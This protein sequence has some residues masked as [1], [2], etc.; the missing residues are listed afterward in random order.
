[1]L[2]SPLFIRLC[3]D[4]VSSRRS[5]EDTEA[6]YVLDTLQIVANMIAQIFSSNYLKK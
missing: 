1:M 5:A 2:D 3:R 6:A 4:V